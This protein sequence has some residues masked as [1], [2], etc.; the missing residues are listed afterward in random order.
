MATVAR[1]LVPVA[2]E[3][4]QVLP[5]EESDDSDDS[6]SE[7]ST[8]LEFRFD[9]EAVEN[10]EGT[11]DGNTLI[12]CFFFFSLFYMW[13]YQTLLQ[14]QGFLAEEF[15]EKRDSAGF[16]MMIATTSPL[17]VVHSVLTVTGLGR[18]ISYDAK[19]TLAPILALA[20]SVYLGAI[21]SLPGVSPDLLLTSLYSVAFLVVSSEAIA[22]PAVYDMAG[23]LPSTRTSM[24]V[25]SG[26]GA[27]GMIVSAI[28]L[29]ARL[30]L[31]GLGPISKGQLETL[32]RVF[33]AVM[34]LSSGLFALL[35][36]RY[37]RPNRHYQRHV[38]AG[39]DR[40]AQK[41]TETTAGLM[42]ATILATKQVWPSFVALILCFGTT[43]TLWPVIP[44]RTCVGTAPGDDT[45]AS[46]WFGL[47]IFVFNIADF[48]GKT[49]YTSLSW[50][51]RVLSPRQ[52]LALA[53]LR[54]CLF[55]PLIL[56][57]SAPQSYD[58]HLARWVVLVSVFL[59]GFSN[60]WLSTVC[61]MRAP[62]AFPSSTP[63]VVVE[64]ASTAL[65]LGLFI[66]IAGGCFMAYALGQTVLS[67]SL[68]AC[69]EGR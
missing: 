42:R 11:K 43:L 13:P 45:L 9:E 61:F 31:N 2:Y 12:W 5:A 57:G 41:D 6:D 49:W 65:V 25:Q 27:C 47:V 17:L 55:F 18:K 40:A 69:F 53:V 4:G 68:G 16:I 60:G 66:G 34:A 32:T 38:V 10:F 64:Q 22:E 30:L 59:L 54:A 46:W 39:E 28:Q 29:G 63:I 3:P 23:L 14:M 37:V 7:S 26:N 50:G 67:A 36:W 15:P 52:Q 35:F 58:P 20:L 33:I 21:V 24:M 51:A 1:R 62:K 44:G 8:G 56:T 48:A 19:M